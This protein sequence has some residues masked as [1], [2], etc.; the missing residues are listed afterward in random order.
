MR[1]KILGFNNYGFDAVVKFGGS[2]LMQPAQAK[3]AIRAIELCREK[4]KNVLVI[5]GGGP[6]NKAIGSIDQQVPLAPTTHHQSCAR[7]QDQTGL[8]ICDPGFSRL[9]KSCST[10]ADARTI[11]AEG[12]IPVLLPSRIICDIDPFEKIWELTADAMSVWFAWLVGAPITLILT[13]MDGIFPPGADFKTAAPVP[14]LQ[15]QELRTW[16]P[17]AVDVCVPEFLASRGGR[18]WVGNGSHTDRLYKALS[19]QPTIGTYIECTYA[20]QFLNAS[21]VSRPTPTFS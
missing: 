6:T 14:K 5:P 9:L 4:G 21:R 17:T 2:L 10:L 7:A 15:A 11:Q 1:Q 13:T 12:Y 19:G 20:D 8:I 3:N 16:G 18:V